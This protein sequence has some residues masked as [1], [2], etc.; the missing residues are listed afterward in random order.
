VADWTDELQVFCA[1]VGSLARGNFGWAR[2]I[3]AE[4]DVVEHVASSIES[5][6]DAVA[7]ELQQGRPVALG[8]EMPLFVPVPEDAGE[9]GR[10]RPCDAGAP[11]WNSP[12]GSNVLTTGLP[13]VAWVLVRLREAASDLPAFTRWEPFD[14]AR[15]GLLLWEAFVTKDAK[16]GSHEEDA[17]IGIKAFCDQLPT[18]GDADG[19]ETPRPL[20]LV[21]A[22][23]LWAGWPLS[24]DALQQ[25][26][27]LV[28][29]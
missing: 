12:V 15:R 18:P 26:C 28:R 3:P 27:V 5:F 2:R 10:A 23:A 17:A 9:L 14:D 13:Q 22:A 8:F 24:P 16:G 25:A 1:D 21:A 20:S 4:S 6:A 11:S 29:A 19:D 7:E